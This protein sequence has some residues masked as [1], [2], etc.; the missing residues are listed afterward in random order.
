MNRNRSADL[1]A[2]GRCRRPDRGGGPG[3]LLHGAAGAARVT[4]PLAALTAYV[5]SYHY[6]MLAAAWLEAPGLCCT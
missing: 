3:C 5:A 2:A 1:A 4:A 6:A